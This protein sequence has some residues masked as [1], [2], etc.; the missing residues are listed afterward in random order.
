MALARSLVR[1]QRQFVRTVFTTTRGSSSVVSKGA[2]NVT[3][4]DE[5]MLEFLACPLSKT[6]LRWD[7]ATSSLICDELGVAYPVNNGMP[8]L[9]PADGH[10]IEAQDR[11]SS[12]SQQPWGDTDAVPK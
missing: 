6:P 5:G 3:E 7:E 4:F 9:R 11:E 12:T 2:Y 10:V 8:N 1:A